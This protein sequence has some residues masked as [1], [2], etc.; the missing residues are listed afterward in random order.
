MAIDI[1]ADGE[2]IAAGGRDGQTRIW[3]ARTGVLSATVEGHH[4][5]VLGVK[6]APDG[7]RLLTLGMDGTARIWSLDGIPLA[8]LQGHGGAIFSGGW[9]NDSSQV[10]TASFDG[11][12]RTWDT[13]RAVLGVTSTP[14]VQ[15]I[16]R[17]AVSRDDR[18]VLTGGADNFAVL[19]DVQDSREL[20]RLPHSAPVLSVAFSPDPATALTIDAAGSAIVWTL[21]SGHVRTPLP[22]ST[23]AAFLSN[24]DIVTASN[25]A[26]EF[27]DRD[28]TK[29][30][31]IDCDYAPNR[32]VID[33]SGRWLF[34][35]GKTNAVLVIDLSRR[36]ESTKLAVEDPDVVGLAASTSIVAITDGT[37]IRTWNLGP[38]WLPRE[39]LTGHKGLIDY[40]WILPDQKFVS[41]GFD[42]T[43]VWERGQLRAKLAATSQTYDTASAGD[44][45]VFATAGTDGHVHIW[46]AKTYANLLQLPSQR[47]TSNV[48]TFTHDH[49]R[50]VSAGNDGRLV[51]WK[52]P[53]PTR[54]AAELAE[55]VRCRV[56]LQLEGGLVL[57][58]DL[59]FDDPTCR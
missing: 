49:S 16:R 4:G 41:S 39:R 38:P 3:G 51:I 26:I 28:G 12:V 10:Y 9:E 33:P 54:T 32:F 7:R 46:D 55:I 23:A 56:P 50:I 24:G 45:G 20:V 22:S 29:L 47:T 52:M 30:A 27:R 53:H 17:L 11:A 25:R 58:R 18:W 44:A 14:Q 21:P 2:T 40:V 1:S 13:A 34:A 43:F 6:I 5:M 42:G 8:S 36:A 31:S 48:V 37:M 15:S 57:P 59:D 19:W 35:V